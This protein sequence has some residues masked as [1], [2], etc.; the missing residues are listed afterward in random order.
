MICFM[1]KL[2]VASYNLPVHVYYEIELTLLLR[3]HF[4]RTM[5]LFDCKIYDIYYIYLHLLQLCHFC[6]SRI[7]D[8]QKEANEMEKKLLQ[9]SREMKFRELSSK[10]G[11]D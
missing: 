10:K 1:Y 5:M 2:T 11:E 4:A 6:H 9:E 7:V 3:M 8:Q